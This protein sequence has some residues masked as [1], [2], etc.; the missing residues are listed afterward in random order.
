[1]LSKGGRDKLLE[2]VGAAEQVS[3]SILFTFRSL[4]CMMKVND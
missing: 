1:M 4:D 2:Q 3:G